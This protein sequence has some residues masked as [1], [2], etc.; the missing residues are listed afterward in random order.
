MFTAKYGKNFQNMTNDEDTAIWTNEGV[1]LIFASDWLYGIVS[2]PTA[3]PTASPNGL[4]RRQRRPRKNRIA[5]SFIR[6]GS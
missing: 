3:A 1:I 2:S 6:K 5:E 4:R